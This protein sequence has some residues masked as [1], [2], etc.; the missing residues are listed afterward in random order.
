MWGAIA[1][2]PGSFADEPDNQTEDQAFEGKTGAEVQK[3]IDRRSIILLPTDEDAKEIEL[4]VHFDSFTWEAYRRATLQAAKSDKNLVLMEAF[5]KLA[6][7]EIKPPVI[8]G[9]EKIFRDPQFRSGLPPDFPPRKY[10]Q[11]FVAMYYY[12]MLDSVAGRIVNPSLG[13]P[14]INPHDQ[15]YYFVYTH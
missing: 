5:G 8:K 14:G 7:A 15:N 10:A 3:E 9:C 13:Q 4:N 1:I 6:D 12:Q 2:A 11:W